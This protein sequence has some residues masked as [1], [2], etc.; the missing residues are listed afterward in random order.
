MTNPIRRLA[1]ATLLAAGVPAWADDAPKP[2]DPP[3]DP[4]KP[5]ASSSIFNTAGP[6][7]HSAGQIVAKLGKS[8]D[9]S[10]TVKVPTTEQTT[11]RRGTAGTHTVERDHD[12]DLTADAKVR[13]HTLPKKADGKPYTDKEYQAFREPAGALGYKAESSDLKPGQTVRLY[14]GKAG[15]DDKPVVTM[16][17]ILADAPK[18][19]DSKTADKKK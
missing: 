7:L 8:S 3:K 11:G 16:V 13:W 18:H 4:P 2:A 10:V 19:D 9:G 15:K 17:M 14:L 6:Q 1:L 12:Y 5:P